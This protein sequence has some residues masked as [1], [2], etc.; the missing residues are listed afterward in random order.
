MNTEHIDDAP[1]A[2]TPTPPEAPDLPP[3]ADFDLGAWFSGVRP[4]E[5]SINIT[6]RG[7]LLADIEAT[8]RQLQLAEADDAAEYGIEDT[9]T[10]SKEALNARLDDLYRAYLDSTV[11]F[12]VQGR[13]V[14]WLTTVEKD[15][16]NGP[17]TRGMS[18][19]DKTA[20]VTRH[21]L[22]RSIVQPEGVTVEH[23]AMLEEAS[24]AQYRALV[25]KF[26]E[27]CSQAPVVSAPTSPSSSANRRG[28]G[29]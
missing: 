19:D 4:T 5:R 20:E 24:G 17:E 2:D 15:I 29:R 23:L 26:F 7:D 14:D 1:P 16:K 9:G 28:R 18:K 6:Q 27:A 11:T 12:R 21:Q 13:S 8:E 25:G 10:N 3:P 22:A